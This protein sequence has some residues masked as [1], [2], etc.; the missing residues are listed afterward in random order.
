[1]IIRILIAC[2][3][4]L[5]AVFFAFVISE[6][7]LSAELKREDQER[8][9]Q[10]EFYE[11]QKANCLKKRHAGECLGICDTCDCGFSNIVEFR[12]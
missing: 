1:M 12:E 11:K 6:F 5:A 2:L 8:E 3:V 7:I 4:M 9:K 10:I